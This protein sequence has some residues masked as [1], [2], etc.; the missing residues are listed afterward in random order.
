MKWQ[1]IKT[2]AVET[3]SEW[4]NDKASRLAAA[5]AY[6]T[7]I[8]LPAL[9]ILI[10]AL[11]GMFLGEEAARGQVVQQLQSLLGQ[12]GA[13]SIEEMISSA[14]KAESRSIWASILSSATL[15]FG[16]TA[17]VIQLQDALNT[18]WEV[19]PK[20]G[21]FIKSFIFNRVLSFGMI[22]SIGFL[23]LVSLV[24]SACLAI[25]SE[26]LGSLAPHLKVLWT[27]VDFVVSVTL[28]AGLFS[29]MFKYLPDAKIAWG[30]VVIGAFLTSLLFNIGKLAIGFYLGSSKIG[31]TYG[32]TGSLVILLVW[33]YYSAQI[34]FLGAEFTQ[35]YAR[36]Y[37]SRIEPE[38]YAKPT[39]QEG[40]AQQGLK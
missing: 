16:A 22:L 1:K 18:I 23:L 37:G 24:I 8:S 9:V 2:V 39:T 4:N 13:K 14:S 27:V 36:R 33:I 29:L 3:F 28:I 26:Y 19:E 34:F 7:I 40:R 20:P 15:A 30:D 31:S 6:Y 12:E 17:V 32:A 11:A 21:S 5:L 38:G 35:V 10:I 25:L